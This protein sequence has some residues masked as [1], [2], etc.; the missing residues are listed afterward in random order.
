MD[1]LLLVGEHR[2]SVSREREREKKNVRFVRVAVVL[3]SFRVWFAYFLISTFKQLFEVI[4]ILCICLSVYIVSFNIRLVA[5][6]HRTGLRIRR[7]RQNFSQFFAPFVC[8]LTKQKK[9][10]KRQRE[11]NKSTH[12]TRLPDIV[13]S[14]STT[15]TCFAAQGTCTICIKNVWLPIIF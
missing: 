8:V 12:K 14:L 7:K 5:E 2:S 15:W 4:D 10:K 11:Q 3:L 1:I 13:K 6:R 9:K